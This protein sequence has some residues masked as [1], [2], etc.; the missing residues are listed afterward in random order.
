MPDTK[1]FRQQLSKLD[2]KVEPSASTNRE[3]FIDGSSSKWMNTIQAAAFLKTTP[4]QIRNLVWQNRLNA[5][6]PFGRLLF[7]RAELENLVVGVPERRS[8]KCRSEK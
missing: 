5:Y 7:S 2:H 3:M 1:R 6:K 4:K 8:T